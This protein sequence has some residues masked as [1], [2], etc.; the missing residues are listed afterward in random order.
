MKSRSV[1]VVALCALLVF[2]A[3]GCGKKS[4]KVKA[5]ATVNGVD[6][7]MKDFDAQVNEMKKQYKDQ[8][9]FEGKEGEKRLLEYKERILDGLIVNEL[10]FQAAKDKGIKISD[11]DVQKQ[12]DS[13]KTGYKDEAQFKK[14]LKDANLTVEE[15]TELLRMQML[16]QRLIES[17]AQS[18]DIS[19]KAVKEYYEK[20]KAQFYEKA[21]K[22]PAQ[23]L[24]RPEDKEVAQK[25]LD[26]LKNGGDFAALAKKYSVDETTA[27]KGGDLGWPSMPRPTEVEKT[28]DAL[29]V[30]QLSG[31]V[32]SSYGWH[33]LTVLEE[34]PARQKPLSEVTDQIK[35]LI[36]GAARAESYQEF[37]KQER[38]KA[39]IEVH[40]K[41]LDH[42]SSKPKKSK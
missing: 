35:Q 39:T 37:I 40:V 8:K 1:L 33:I 24:F 38:A 30:G 9:M 13:V 21:A 17:L 2:G 26:E 3:F 41:G 4:S 7:P 29:K 31:L 32:Q 22:R 16:Q 10:L 42:L 27:G 19:D 23:I 28:V 6:I 20:N 14:S 11:K 18:A 34:R 25:V 5:A 36:A 15:L 12:V